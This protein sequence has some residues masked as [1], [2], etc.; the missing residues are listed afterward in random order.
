[1]NYRHAFHAG[2]HTE[3][4]KHAVLTFILEG[5]R[6]KPQP[7]SVLDTHA[8]IGLYDLTSEQAQ[9]TGEYRHGVARA[10]DRGLASAP[11]YVGLIEAMNPTGLQAYPGSPE[12]V[13][14][15][16]R[17]D[18]RLTA[19]E[20]HPLDA[21]TLKAAYRRDPRIS[22]HHRDGY[23]AIGG[24]LPPSP[25]RGLVLIDPPY[26]KT[27]EAAR[28]ASALATGLK[29]W[30]NGI[31]MAWY[32]AK[33]SEIGDVLA[34]SATA[35]GFPKALRAEFFPY[36]PGEATLPGSGL[37]ILN[38]PWKLDEKIAAL[39]EELTGVLGEGRG[40]WKVDRL[41]PP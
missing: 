32:P 29:R 21:E 11:G 9:K 19:C 25:R 28:L 3:V 5:L 17:E 2:N 15:L 16:L 23:E 4:F 39:C 20:L 22:I 31:F 10:L 24:L 7:F 27:D 35:G 40:G 26:E 37:L 6:E 34:R 18:D 12:I 14:R 30:P 38:T 41:T 33:D 1:M 36:A 13:R 8:G